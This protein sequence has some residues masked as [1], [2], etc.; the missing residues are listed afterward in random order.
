M[1]IILKHWDYAIL[2]SLITL[3]L[4]ASA[5]AAN[6]EL[7][8]PI[9]IYG[10]LALTSPL[11]IVLIPIYTVFLYVKSKL[12]RPLI[13]LLLAAIS[14]TGLNTCSSEIA[15][16]FTMSELYS[17]ELSIDEGDYLRIDEGFTKLHNS[18]YVVAEKS[19]FAG[20]DTVTYYFYYEIT[21]LTKNTNQRNRIFVSDIEIFGKSLPSENE[22]TSTVAYA[23][24]A[25]QKHVKKEVT[26]AVKA[27]LLPGQNFIFINMRSEEDFKS[28]Q[29]SATIL[30]I[31]FTI[32]T[33][34]F[35]FLAYRKHSANKNGD[36][37]ASVC[38]T[39]PH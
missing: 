25:P 5:F 33:L 30:S 14:A 29:Q 26:A 3:L 8:K 19:K 22:P 35:L 37:S 9:V 39:P 16:D 34:T 15:K 7:K 28:T 13:F 32:L 10:S 4:F 1:D 38:T 31:F 12:A 23:Y 27:S 21:P 17:E 6:K 2:I 36:E 20:Q 18:Q 11:P 24:I